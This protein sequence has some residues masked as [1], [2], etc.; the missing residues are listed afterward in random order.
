M[1]ILEI[2]D[3]TTYRYREYLGLERKIPKNIFNNFWKQF[4]DA[5]EEEMNLMIQSLEERKSY[6]DITLMHQDRILEFLSELIVPYDSNIEKYEAGFLRNFIATL[7]YLILY[8]SSPRSILTIVPMIS[9]KGTFYITYYS[10]GN[11]VHHA[12]PL[13]DQLIA[14]SKDLVFLKPKKE[15]T[16]FIAENIHLDENKTL[17]ENPSWILDN[18]LAY[19]NSPVVLLE[20][21]LDRAIT[22]LH[23]QEA[24]LKEEYF[25]YLKNSAAFIKKVTDIYS[26][27]AQLTIRLDGSGYI[28]YDNAPYTNV[29]TR[30]N[31]LVSEDFSLLYDDYSVIVGGGKATNLRKQSGG[32]FPLSVVQPITKVK[33]LP[34]K[35]QTTPS[36]KIFT[37][38]VRGKFNNL[39]TLGTG[40][41]TQ[42]IFTATLQKAP[43]QDKGITITYYHN[44][45]KRV[46]KD[47]NGTL[48]GDGKGTVDIATGSITLI[49]E[50]DIPY[51]MVIGTGNG[52]QTSYSGTVGTSVNPGSFRVSFVVDGVMLLAQDDG[53]GSIVGLNISSGTID[54]STGAYSIVFGLAPQNSTAISAKW[55]R[56]IDL[57]PDNT[58]IV[59]ITYLSRDYI[60]ITEVGLWSNIQNTL[61]A[62]ATFP[63]IELPSYE[64]HLTI[65]IVIDTTIPYQPN[66]WSLIP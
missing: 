55:E 32:A 30:L 31:G 16:N 10:N 7:N 53:S 42:K 59:E 28:D 24:L 40:N 26:Y 62:Y 65:N 39:E 18:F 49:T 23:A 50:K 21:F 52:T 38:I 34:D 64:F 48:I 4:L 15:Y 27:G 9:R 54:Y 12:D 5:V 58:S 22:D 61:V 11:A 25:Y 46:V 20:I 35:I 1:T 14:N 3:R 44:N 2:E 60:P 37:V 47:E 56:T 41:G 13:S 17:D 63:P 45:I 43:L 6:Y 19:V 36:H 8:K 29:P 66:S 33:V 51:D 57:P